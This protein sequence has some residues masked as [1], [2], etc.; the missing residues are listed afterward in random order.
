[1]S[2]RQAD[3][4][5]ELDEAERLVLLVLGGTVLPGG[6]CQYGECKVPGAQHR[7]GVWCNR[8]ARKMERRV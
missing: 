1:V 5:A 7:N 4:D 6:S 8:H 2:G 3:R